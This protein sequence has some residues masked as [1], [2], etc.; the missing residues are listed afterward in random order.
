MV[1]RRR[2]SEMRI[3]YRDC[4]CCK[5]RSDNLTRSI[6]RRVRNERK[7]VTRYSYR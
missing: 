3:E 4:I 1:D 7:V 5:G 6:D 2:M